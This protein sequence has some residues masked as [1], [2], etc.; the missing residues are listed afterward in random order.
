MDN[1]AFLKQ[2]RAQYVK[3]GEAQL[4]TLTNYLCAAYKD[5]TGK[6]ADQELWEAIREA[7]NGQ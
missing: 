6:D 4:D 5:L 3:E 7:V 1:A 2:M